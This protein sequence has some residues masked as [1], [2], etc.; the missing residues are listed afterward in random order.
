MTT[1]IRP[2]LLV[3]DHDDTRDLLAELLERHGHVVRAARSGA[4][5]LALLGELDPCLIIV[6]LLLPDVFG[7]ELVRRLRAEA[8]GARIPIYALS[9]FSNLWADALAAGCDG[10]LTKPVTGSDLRLVVEEHCANGPS[11]TKVA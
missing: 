3:D 7:I 11:S 8:A 2:V 10:F 1:T 5:A 4:E 6:D 9:G